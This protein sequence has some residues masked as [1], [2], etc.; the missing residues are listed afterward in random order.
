MLM[1]RKF[2]LGLILLVVI[3]LSFPLQ[4]MA[5]PAATINPSTG[6]TAITNLQGPPGV[7]IGGWLVPATGTSYAVD[8]TG[9]TAT[10]TYMLVVI[11]EAQT[12]TLSDTTAQ[13]VAKSIDM[14]DRDTNQKVGAGLITAVAD[15][16]STS[17]SDQH[18]G[19]QG[20]PSQAR[21]MWV[22]TNATEWNLQPSEFDSNGKP[23]SFKITV[24]GPTGV[25]GFFKWYWPKALLD[26]TG[27][28]ANTLAGFVDGDQVSTTTQTL[29]DGGVVVSMNLTYSTHT[30][31]TKKALP[32]SLAASKKSVKKKKR[33]SLFG[34]LNPKKARQTIKLFRK[35]K[36]Q[37]S[38]KQIGVAKTNGKGYFSRKFPVTQTAY[39]VAK[40]KK[41]K[42]WITSPVKLVKAT[43]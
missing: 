20:P 26:L 43:K 29:A 14:Y 9:L 16:S 34:W 24:T 21:G 7:T 40:Y 11:G 35:I 37:K 38:Y 41:G 18:G 28:N 2:N 5:D 39:Y 25:A 13:I 12:V 8:W 15:M 3:A 19:T 6:T 17:S 31:M 36:G 4:S 1:K 27:F 30:V 10:T 33:V 32:L 22:S 42:K 23:K